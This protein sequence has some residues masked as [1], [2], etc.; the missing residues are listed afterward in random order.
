MMRLGFLVSP[1]LVGVVADATSLRW[2]LLIVPLSGLL[3]VLLAGVLPRR[4]PPTER[5]VAA[6]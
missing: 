5:I 3:V 1:P 2:G 6:G 4:P